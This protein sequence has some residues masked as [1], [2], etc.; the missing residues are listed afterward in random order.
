MSKQNYIANQNNDFVLNLA[1]TNSDG[2]ERNITGYDILFT[3]KTD[4]RIADDDESVIKIEGVISD[5]PGG[6]ASITL[7]KEVT[8]DMAGTYYYQVDYIDTNGVR[9]TFEYGVIT[10]K[11]AVSIREPA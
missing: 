5:G 9:N 1:F 11:K 3:A 6:E 4:K 2:T 10:F 8:I 7:D